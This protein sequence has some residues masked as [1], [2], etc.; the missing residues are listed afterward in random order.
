LNLLIRFA[1]GAMCL[2]A[3]PLGAQEGP[4]PQED[5]CRRAIT[6]GLEQLRRIP[7]GTARRDDEDRKKL[8]SDMERLVET[9]RRQGVSECQTWTLMM[10]KAFNQ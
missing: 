6:E 2:A 1:L 10:G 4:A 8:L 5:N 7:P 3:I 9:N